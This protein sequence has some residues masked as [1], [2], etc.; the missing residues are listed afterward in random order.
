MSRCRIVVLLA[1]L[2][3][4]SPAMAEG[5][6]KTKPVKPASAD[7]PLKE[8]WSGY[9][10]ASPEIRQMQDAESENPAMALNSAGEALWKKVE[11][12]AKKSCASCH[13]N[14][15]KSMHGTAAR[16]PAYFPLVKKPIS[17]ENRINLCR[18]KFMQARAL[19]PESDA[20]L[21]LS[22]YVKRQSSGQAINVPGDGPLKPFLEKGKA[23]FTSRRGQLNISC[24]Q[25]HNK[26]AGKRYRSETISQGHANGFPA[27]RKSWKGTGSLLRQVNQ[28]LG[29][30]RAT[31]LKAGS[32]SLVNLELYLAWRASGLPVETP[33]VRE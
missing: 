11:G 17:I 4:S 23:Y 27:Y 31:R 3:L 25:C 26:Y 5:D 19:A 33:A 12:K 16:F 13:G 18:Q 21:A 22:I 10:Y 32:D 2:L 8:L 1:V 6:G 29:R 30:M 15:A 28:C 24:A 9:H 7:N 14:A 20:M